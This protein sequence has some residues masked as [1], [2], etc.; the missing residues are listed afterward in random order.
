MNDEVTIPQQIAHLEAMA[1]HKRGSRG[2]GGPPVFCLLA[3]DH[4]SGIVP[5]V[6]GI[7]DIDRAPLAGCVTLLLRPEGRKASIQRRRTAANT[8]N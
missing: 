7:A 3:A 1:H 4:S 8:A 5:N 2:A 6:N